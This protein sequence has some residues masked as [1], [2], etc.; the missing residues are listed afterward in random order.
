VAKFSDG[1][2]GL[3]HEALHALAVDNGIPN[4]NSLSKEQLIYELRQRGI[5]SPYSRPGSNESSTNEAPDGFDSFNVDEN[6]RD[7]LQQTMEAYHEDTPDAPVKKWLVTL[8]SGAQ[9]F[10]YG[11]DEG[12]DDIAMDHT[13]VNA[14]TV[15]DNTPVSIQSTTPTYESMFTQPTPVE[16]PSKKRR[17]RLTGRR[18]RHAAIEEPVDL[19]SRRRESFDW[20]R[21][22]TEQAEI[23]NFP[24]HRRRDR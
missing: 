2:G 6:E 20:F 14:D 5:R 13:I 24:R 1:L 10:L 18:G 22:P 3:S 19:E 12:A 4:V 7:E 11:T 8:S 17:P 23:L 15:D 16:Q 21:T 9:V